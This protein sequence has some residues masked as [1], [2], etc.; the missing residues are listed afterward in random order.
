MWGRTSALPKFQVNE[1]FV[2]GSFCT[3]LCN[4]QAFVQAVSREN[5][6]I[7]HCRVLT[8]V[9][10]EEYTRSMTSTPALG[11][12]VGVYIQVFS[13]IF[14]HFDV[15]KHCGK[16]DNIFG[17]FLLFVCIRHHHF[18]G[19]IVY[20]CCRLYLPVFRL[21]QFWCTSI[22]TNHSIQEKKFHNSQK[23]IPGKYCWVPII[24]RPVGTKKR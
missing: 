5:A 20:E 19:S 9:V 1:K 23:D 14:C 21:L 13:F 15:V 24:Y 4:I 8:L 22:M 18:V 16:N 7:L 3:S 17:T 10:T 6:K 12:V 11:F 2:G